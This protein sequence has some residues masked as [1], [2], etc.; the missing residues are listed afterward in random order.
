MKSSYLIY[1]LWLILSLAALSFA[2]DNAGDNPQRT[3]PKMNLQENVVQA[4]SS[5][6]QHFQVRW[7]PY[8]EPYIAIQGTVAVPVQIPVPLPSLHVAAGVDV[9]FAPQHSI[10][11]RGRFGVMSFIV[12]VGSVLS[13]ELIYRYYTPAQDNYYFGAG[14]R[15]ILPWVEAEQDQKNVGWLWTAL[16]GYEF[17]FQEDIPVFLELGINGTVQATDSFIVVPHL[18]MGVNYRF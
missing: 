11:L 17:R 10:G 8:L 16:L 2:Q 1:S 12:A 14:L 9:R 7:Q 6:Q 4:S 13:G 18:S 3:T 5:A 15:A